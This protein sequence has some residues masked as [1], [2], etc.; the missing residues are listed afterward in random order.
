[1]VFMRD[2]KPARGGHRMRDKALR[3]ALLLIPLGA[4]DGW[5]RYDTDEKHVL[6]LW[7]DGASFDVRVARLSG[8]ERG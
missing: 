2:H 1:M 6:H 7:A 3:E 4:H 8:G 5:N